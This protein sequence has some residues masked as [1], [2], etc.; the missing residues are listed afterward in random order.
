MET[1]HIKGK[2]GTSSIHVG[3]HLKNLGNYLPESRTVIITD[4]NIKKYYG[5]EFPDLPVITIGTGEEIKTLSSVEF[6]LKELI[7]YSCDRSSFIVGI[8]G[9]IVSDIT[10]FVASVFLR[11]I[12]F[13]FVS[14]S[15]LSQVDASVGGKNGVNL[16]AYKNMV[17][18]FNQPEFVICDLGLLQTLPGPEISNGFAEIVKHALICDKA[19]FEF[20]ETNR[21][22]ALSLDDQT[23][24]RLV[25]DC[26]K[27]KSGIVQRD[28]KEAGE[29]RKLNFGHTIGHAI[30]KIERAGH[31]RAVSMG[32]V[33]AARFSR[34]RGMISKKDVSRI[35][36]LLQDLNLP[37]GLNY[38]PGAVIN[39]AGKDKKKEGKDL[40]YVFLEEIGTARVE[41]IGFHELNEFILK[42]FI[43]C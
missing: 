2:L 43:F 12:K 6:I 14:T 38:D 8:G 41:K 17:G 33:A 20:I 24:Y 10:G 4:E 21:Q 22:K 30:E 23:I 18:V 11:G 39:A 5:N 15:L 25:A 7:R 40:F 42:T 37:T 34:E 27:I 32:M 9:G 28:E 36:A 31:G 1:I 13:G 3:E 19:L 16:D 29:R 35:M 26:V